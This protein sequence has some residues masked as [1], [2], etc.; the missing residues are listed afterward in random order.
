MTLVCRGLRG[1]TTASENSKEAILEATRELLT[2]LQKSNSFK[3]DDIAATFFTT[4]Q[5][6]NAEFPAVAARQMGW[7]DVPLICG[8]EMNIPDS[9]PMCI[10]V[11]MLINTNKKPQEMAHLYLREAKNLRSKGIS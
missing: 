3:L 11:M 6:L 10:R 2:E 7:E 4:T 9:L 1:A 5:D 8:H